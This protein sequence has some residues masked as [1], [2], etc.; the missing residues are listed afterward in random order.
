MSEEITKRI[1]QVFPYDGK[2]E[3]TIAIGVPAPMA[4]GSAHLGY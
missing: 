4:T 3:I 2:Q 1:A